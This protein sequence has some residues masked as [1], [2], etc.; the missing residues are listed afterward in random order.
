M[1]DQWALWSRTTGIKVKLDAMDWADALARMQAGEYDVID[2]AFYS[3]E[4]DAWLDF[5]SAYA[6]IDV[7]IFHNNKIG[8]ITDAA[9]LVNFEVA[10]K[11]GDSCIAILKGAGVTN[12]VEY[13]SYE[14]VVDAA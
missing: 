1:V 9:S 3:E 2:T 11:A 6:T 13:P 7:P 12:I 4:R 14:A 10:V 5:S 8:G